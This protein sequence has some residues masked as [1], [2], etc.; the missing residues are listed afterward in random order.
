MKQSD[1]N[2][3]IQIRQL[4]KEAYDY[5]F[6]HSDGHCKSS[7]GHI[8]LDFG[9]YWEDKNCE[10]KITGVNIYSYVLGPSRSHYFKNLDTALATVIQWHSDQ[11]NTDYN[12]YGEPESSINDDFYLENPDA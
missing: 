1:W 9:N 2:K 7:E 10:L 6:Q 8:S 3:L 4:L 5:Y 11:M 12:E